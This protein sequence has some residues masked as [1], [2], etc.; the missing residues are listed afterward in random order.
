MIITVPLSVRH[1]IW[2]YMIGMVFGLLCEILGY[3]GRILIS[4]NDFDSVWF[5]LF[6]QSNS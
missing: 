6:R 3:I 1:R 5:L 2:G 4:K